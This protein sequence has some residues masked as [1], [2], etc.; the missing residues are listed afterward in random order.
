[1][2]YLDIKLLT[3]AIKNPNAVPNFHSNYQS[4]VQIS[5]KAAITVHALRD[6][7][8][9]IFQICFNFYLCKV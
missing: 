4:N 6:Y 9:F 3:F 2:V 1:M 8:Q 5:L 7:A